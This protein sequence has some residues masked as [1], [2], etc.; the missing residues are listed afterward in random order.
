MSFYDNFELNFSGKYPSQ[1]VSDIA[2]CCKMIPSPHYLC[3]PDA[4]GLH[5]NYLFGQISIH[6]PPLPSFLRSFS[7]PSSCFSYLLLRLSL[8]ALSAL[9][10][11]TK[12]FYRSGN[13]SVFISHFLPLWVYNSAITASLWERLTAPY[14]SQSD[15]SMTVV[16]QNHPCLS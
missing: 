10:W 9:L 8:T 2:N 5:S 16:I 13:P 1:Y 14:S 15:V 6:P 7:F 3:F 4:A 11:G 12:G